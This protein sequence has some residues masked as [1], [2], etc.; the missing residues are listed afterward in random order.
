MKTSELLDI[1]LYDLQKMSIKDLRKLSNRLFTTA[2]IR[3]NRLRERKQT[4]NAPSL[5]KKGV[6]RGKTFSSRFKSTKFTEKPFT[7][8]ERNNNLRYRNKLIGEINRAQQFM[9]DQTSTIR[10]FKQW[11]KN[12]TKGL[13][14]IGVEVDFNTMPAN[15][16]KAFFQL[17]DEL[18]NSQELVGIN[19]KELLK[20][21]SKRFNNSYGGRR[22]GRA[23]STKSK[24]WKTL[25]SDIK[26]LGK[27]EKTYESKKQDRVG[28]S[29]FSIDEDDL[30]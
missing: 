19:Y 10:G 3:I 4:K 6:T 25:V 23:I 13:Q 28:T 30:W 12:V 21:V 22:S 9:R 15:E 29:N 20:E 14:D 26:Q 2:N 27:S 11:E 8:K 7:Q 5:S 16:Q 1:S 18:K 17:Y 24:K